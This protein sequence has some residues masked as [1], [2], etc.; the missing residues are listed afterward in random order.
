MIVRTS[1]RLNLLYVGKYCADLISWL[2]S[3]IRLEGEAV[4]LHCLQA[5]ELETLIKDLIACRCV[6][7]LD[8]NLH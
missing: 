7:E 1:E 6:R 5:P 2:I 3:E 4:W 8:L